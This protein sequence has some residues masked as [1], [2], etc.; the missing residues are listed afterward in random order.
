MLIDSSYFTRGSRRIYNATAG[1][2]SGMPNPAAAE[3]NAAIESFVAELQE[4]YLRLMLGA[5]VGN[6]VHCYLV[7][8]DEDESTPKVDTYEAVCD[9][10]KESFAD[11]V[12]F[13]IL[14]ETQT[15]A[16]VTGLVRLKCANE[17]IT[18]L[19]KQTR[20]WNRMVERNRDFMQWT[21]S[22][23]CPLKGICITNE[24][25]TKVN[26]FNL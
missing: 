20:T 21:L 24:M 23:N 26:Y 12:F 11:Y 7:C 9:Q 25:L 13:D 1:T 10:L 3:V 17:Y 15:T 2:G 6:K 19:A 4:E 18:P 5:E 14:R 16:T 22:D 8:K